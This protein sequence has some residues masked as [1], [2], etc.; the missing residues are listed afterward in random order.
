MEPD[1]YQ[2]FE[3]G[4]TIVFW[5]DQRPDG[6]GAYVTAIIEEYDPED[7]VYIVTDTED[8]GYGI[9]DDIIVLAHVDLDELEKL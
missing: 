6:K 7:Y 2:K 9:L 1:E 5:D 3:V 8:V 4:T